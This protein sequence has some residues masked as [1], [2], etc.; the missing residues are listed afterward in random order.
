MA[1]SPDFA[2][3]LKDLLKILPFQLVRLVCRQKLAIVLES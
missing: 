1:A 3:F 2:N